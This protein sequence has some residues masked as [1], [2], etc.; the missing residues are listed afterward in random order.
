MIQKVLGMRKYH[1][2]GQKLFL[3]ISG[4]ELDL[5]ATRELFTEAFCLSFLTNVL[6]GLFFLVGNHRMG[7]TANLNVNF[8]KPVR[9]GS[10]IVV[11]IKFNRIEKSKKVFLTASMESPDGKTLYADATTLFI[12]TKV[13]GK[14]REDTL[15]LN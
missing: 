1:P 15:L 11:R 8:R 9:A 2:L 14:E 4:L 5:T 3:Q 12:M 6:V 13:N 7:F 10:D